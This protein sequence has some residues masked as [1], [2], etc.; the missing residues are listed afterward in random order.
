MPNL[1]LEAQ[2]IK[3]QLCPKDPLSSGDDS[4]QMFIEQLLC[5]RHGLHVRGAMINK[6]H[7]HYPP[8]ILVAERQ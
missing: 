2:P 6:T 1:V 3:V 4:Q 5:I 7:D 8:G